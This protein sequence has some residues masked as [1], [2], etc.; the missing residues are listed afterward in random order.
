MARQSVVKT[1]AGFDC[2]FQPS[3]DKRRVMALAEMQFID[4]AEAVHL[5]GPPARGNPSQPGARPRGCQSRRS[6]YFA[7][8]ADIIATLA[9]A[10]RE[11]TL[12]EKIRYFYRFSLLMVDE[13]GYLPATPGRGNLFFQLVNARYEKAP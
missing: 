1:L 3:L 8:L 6:I 5:T 12:R 9:S 13:M 2:S 10:E 11:G 7:S 4:R